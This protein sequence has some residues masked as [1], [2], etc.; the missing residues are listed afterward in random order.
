MCALAL[1]MVPAAFAQK[2]GA[3]AP[4]PVKNSELDAPLFYQLLLAEMELRSGV[5]GNAFDTM[6]DAARRTRDEALFR[7]T[8]EIALQARAGEQA[9]QAVSAWRAALP[10]SAEALRYQVQLLMALN[11]PADAMEP[12]GLLLSKATPEER[13][14]LISTLPRLLQRSPDRTQAA[15][16]A[17][18][19]LKPYTDAPET[20]TAARVALGRLWLAAGDTARVVALLERAHADDPDAPGPALLAIEMLPASASADAVIADY[21]RQPKSEP[22]VR[23][24]YVRTL[25]MQQRYGEAVTQLE[26][27]TRERPDVA[28]PWLTL[29]ALHLE[30][31]HPKEAEEALKRYVELAQSGKPGAPTPTTGDEEDDDVT[32]SPERGLVQAWLLLAQAAEMRGDYA[33][34]EAWL[35]RV[36]SPQRALEVQTRRATLFARQGKLR[37]ARELVRKVPERSPEDARAKLLAEAQVLRDVKRWRDA[38]DLLG[39]ANERFLNDADLLYEQAM[40]AEKLNRMTDMERL[41]RKVI[42]IKPDH[43]H[44]YNALGY[45]LADRN[46]RL[47]EAKALIEKALEMSPGEPF[48][49]DSLGWVQYRMG[50]RLEA[51]R[52]L[53]KAYAAR[54]D[55]EIAAHLGEVLWVDGQ[56]E[57]A[58]RVLSEARRRDAKNEVLVET[59]ARLKVDL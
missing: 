36:D 44:A 4:G 27:L 6:L 18:Q 47:P 14:G 33:G 56:R 58:R 53:R 8:V 15:N 16:L 48:I 31:H 59:L 3:A 37:E 38:Y 52:L 57:E 1:A 11:R 19:L 34:A 9:L 25:A 40:T 41:L 43:H 46:L 30:L 51:L 42:E 54:P 39:K 5:A 22:A 29:G 20:R 21:L 10:D 23:L 12:M 17:E 13:P 26:Q 50:N 49:T 32:A 2:Q 24:A 35:D 7:R 45:S 55:I 28:P